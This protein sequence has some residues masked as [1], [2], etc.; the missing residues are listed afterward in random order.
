M[1]K[2]I[3]LFLAAFCLMFASVSAIETIFLPTTHYVNGTEIHMTAYWPYVAAATINSNP[4]EYKIRI[5]NDTNVDRYV[6]FTEKFSDV[7]EIESASH[8]YS[9]EST[10]FLHMNK[11]KFANVFV[12]AAAPPNPGVTYLTMKI[13]NTSGTDANILSWNDQ[14]RL[15]TEV[16]HGDNVFWASLIFFF[17]STV[18]AIPEFPLVAIPIGIVLGSFFVISRRKAN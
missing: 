11:Y 10:G 16:D 13:K 12:P 9:L 7:F 8:A 1:N 17:Y 3:L 14:W 6:D 15:T 18:P 4:F 5:Q 2:K